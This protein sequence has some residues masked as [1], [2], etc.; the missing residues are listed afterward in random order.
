[1]NFLCPA[2]RT[3]LPRAQAL[4]VVPCTNCGVE[5]DLTR[6]DTAP[7]T[8]RLW[9]DADLTGEKL[10]AF[11]LEKQLAAGGM[12][13]VY[14][15][16]GPQGRCA[17]KVL[18][19]LLAAEPGLRTRFRRE[20]AALRALAHPGVVRILDEGEERGF[21]WYAMERIDGADLRQ[22]IAQGPMPAA[23]VA[24]LARRLLGTLGEV[25]EKGFVHRDIKPG[26]I[27][28]APDGA[29]LCDFGIA[30]FDGAST[31]TESA[32]V[33]GSLR[34]MS[35]EQRLG[36]PSALSDLYA[37]GIV[38]HECLAGG[39]PGEQELPGSTPRR[40]R[41]LIQALLT[42]RPAERP[43]SAGEGLALLEARAFTPARIGVAA[44]LA[45][46]IAAGGVLLARPQPPAPESPP[47]Q[48]ASAPL[49]AP[50]PVQQNLL[51]NQLGVANQQALKAPEPIPQRQA[52]ASTFKGA[53][54]KQVQAIEP[55]Q[56]GR[57]EV[58]VQTIDEPKPK[59]PSI[60][61]KKSMAKPSGKVAPTSSAESGFSK[62]AE[63]PATKAP[64]KGKAKKSRIDYE[65]PRTP[66][67]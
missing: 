42:E 6:I 36:K 41:K 46:A 67:D 64:G 62:A 37:V 31:L 25:H 34:Y 12:G 57:P 27:L 32:A 39:V 56:M 22:R 51:G 65:K 30:R 52:N 16:Q 47:L 4:A 43:Q 29:K 19:A 15:A 5:V 8:A 38:L 59:V 17:V 40:L 1:M 50:E 21:C 20:A 23:E 44:G 10:G 18:S 60:G 63:V 45:L 26:N 53:P 54:E 49:K 14:E 55:V 33:L 2:C 3:P 24:E 13:I 48:Q 58:Q 9:P 28:L 35:P 66:A 7:G 61:T 11:Q